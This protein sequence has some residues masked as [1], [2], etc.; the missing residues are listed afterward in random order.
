MLSEG[1]RL[2]VHYLLQWIHLY[3]ELHG[4][5]IPSQILVQAAEK[6][7]STSDA[8]RL[9]YFY[10][11]DT[12]KELCGC[13]IKMAP[14]DGYGR[15]SK[16][17]QHDYVNCV[18]FAH[19]TVR[20]YVD[21]GGLLRDQVAKLATPKRVLAQQPLKVVFE[22]AH[23]LHLNSAG[24]QKM[25]STDSRDLI[26]TMNTDFDVSC[27]LSA[28]YALPKMAS[29]IAQEEHLF[30]LAFGLLD[31]SNTCFRSLC[32]VAKQVEDVFGWFSDMNGQFWKM[33]SIKPG[34]P[35]AMQLLCLLSWIDYTESNFSL[36]RRFVERVGIR[37]LTQE[38][39]KVKTEMLIDDGETIDCVIDG[40]VIEAVAQGTLPTWIGHG[41]QQLLD[42]SGYLFDPAK[43]LLSYIAG[44]N[45][46][47]RGH[48]GIIRK[49]LQHGADPNARKQRVTLLQIA[50]YNEDDAAV[51]TLLEAKADANN[52]GSV[53]ESPWEEESYMSRYN[54]LFGASPLYICRNY[55]L[56]GGKGRSSLVISEEDMETMLVQHG[57]KS[58]LRPESA[59]ILRS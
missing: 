57:A 31:P 45:I 23:R 2:V 49:L 27:A 51:S 7:P 47:F 25:A 12:I 1:E 55:G 6:C 58:F 32:S 3:P 5:P 8:F 56:F 41:F 50:I 29:E 35:S 10:D 16:G 36:I 28:L 14:E 59:I 15:D 34:S 38:R 39:L 13:V 30:R 43:V 17:R 11:E 24:M 52:T 21:S 53:A 33:E 26:E 46:G 40:S 9:G 42:L 4:D 18:S 19:Y 48:D 22:E 44:D 20:E 37:H 54:K